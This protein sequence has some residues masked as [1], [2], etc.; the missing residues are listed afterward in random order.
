[1]VR[2]QQPGRGDLVTDRPTVEWN[3]PPP[4]FRLLLTIAFVVAFV[5]GVAYELLTI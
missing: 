3:T 2:H 1:M 5:V 4:S